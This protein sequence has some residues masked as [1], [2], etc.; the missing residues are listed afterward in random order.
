MLLTLFQY[1][2]FKLYNITQARTHETTPE[3][4]S[5]SRPSFDFRQLDHVPAD[6]QRAHLPQ[7][8][9]RQH[10]RGRIRGV[11]RGRQKCQ[12]ASILKRAV[13]LHQGECQ[14]SPEHY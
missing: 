14:R 10:L 2:A 11:G 5:N 8:T 6:V 7:N 4:Y 12:N 3:T 9:R 13:N 1:P